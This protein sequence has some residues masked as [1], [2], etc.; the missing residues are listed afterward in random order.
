MFILFVFCG[1]YYT[2]VSYSIL[3]EVLYKKDY[4]TGWVRRLMDPTGPNFRFG[5]EPGLS[6]TSST[7][8]YSVWASSKSVCAVLALNDD[9]TVD[10]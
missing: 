9:R 2:W 8:T 5:L 7:W 6:G 4:W 3:G 10:C 1:E